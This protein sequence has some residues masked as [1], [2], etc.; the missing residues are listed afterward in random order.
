MRVVALPWICA[1]STWSR[2]ALYVAMSH[3]TAGAPSGQGERA[4]ERASRGAVRSGPRAGVMRASRHHP[5]ARA[6]R[7]RGRR[8]GLGALR[9]RR[10]AHAVHER[11]QGF[12]VGRQQLLHGVLAAL[13]GIEVGAEVFRRIAG[14]NEADECSVPLWIYLRQ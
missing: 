11:A 7:L 1:P 13:V 5:A 3:L 6:L 4:C 14:F 12:D 8:R 2:A 9:T 10:G